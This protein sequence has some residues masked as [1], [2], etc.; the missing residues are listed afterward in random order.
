MEGT[1]RSFE[2][3]WV[4]GTGALAEWLSEYFEQPVHIEENAAGG[5][6]D[7]TDSP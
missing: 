6:S 2:H 3:E 4:N 1:L 7:D 5:L